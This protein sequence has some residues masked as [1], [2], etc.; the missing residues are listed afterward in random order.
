MDLSTFVNTYRQAADELSKSEERFKQ[1]AQNWGEQG[2]VQADLNPI[3]T[4]PNLTPA[5]FVGAIN[6]AG[7]IDTAYQTVVG[8]MVKLRP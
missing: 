3:L 6:A 4:D 1:L 5:D 2:W 8:T 7:T